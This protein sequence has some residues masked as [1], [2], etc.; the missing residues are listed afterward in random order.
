MYVVSPFA[1]ITTTNDAA[2]SP[3]SHSPSLDRE[4]QVRH[5]TDPP[6]ITEWSSVPPVLPWDV[7]PS[8]T[9]QDV[10]TTVPST[11]RKDESTLSN[12]RLVEI[13]SLHEHQIRE[14]QGSVDYD[15]HSAH[16]ITTLTVPIHKT[17]PPVTSTPATINNITIT[18]VPMTTAPTTT[19]TTSASHENALDNRKITNHQLPIWGPV[20]STEYGLNRRKKSISRSLDAEENIKKQDNEGSSSSTTPHDKFKES[21]HED[22][23]TLMPEGEVGL[24]TEGEEKNEEELLKLTIQQLEAVLQ[25]KPRNN[26]EPYLPSNRMEDKPHNDNHTHFRS[27][28]DVE[29]LRKMGLRSRSPSKSKLV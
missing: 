7:T 4:R 12:E 18:T 16:P 28:T 26:K 13:E 6:A 15:G 3:V 21:M 11:R 24:T 2:A 10:N 22:H 19:T 8:V 25:R 29:K 23:A 14:V 5:P 27:F 17:T 20:T 9:D 1:G